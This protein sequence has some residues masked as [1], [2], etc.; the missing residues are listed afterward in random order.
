M[1]KL[2]GLMTLMM[3][4]YCSLAQCS[5]Y[6]NEIDKFTGD[7]VR[8]TKDKLLNF[9]FPSAYMASVAKINNTYA[10]KFTYQSGSI[11]SVDKGSELMLMLK[12]GEVITLESNEYVLANGT[13][14]SGMTSW[15]GSMTYNLSIEQLKSLSQKPINMVRLYTDKG[16]AELE[17]KSKYQKRI[18]EM[19]SCVK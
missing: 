13:T 6:R 12:D 5:Y 2:L 14:A 15:S 19:I 9:G 16:Y 11:Y 3:L 18:N 10:L 17:L 4:S 8:I 7:T 1:K